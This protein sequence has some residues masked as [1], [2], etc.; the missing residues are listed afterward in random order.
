LVKLIVCPGVHP[1]HERTLGALRLVPQLAQ[2]NQAPFFGVVLEVRQRTKEAVEISAVVDRREPSLDALAG[3]AQPDASG[4][5]C[6]FRFGRYVDHRFADGMWKVDLLAVQ[7][8]SA[9][10]TT[11]LGK[12]D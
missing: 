7:K 9:A 12:T 10:D 1:D 5:A 8:Y 4:L 6:I 2:S 3:A 11:A